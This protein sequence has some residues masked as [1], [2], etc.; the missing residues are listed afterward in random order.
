MRWISTPAYFPWMSP[1]YVKVKYWFLV[2]YYFFLNFYFKA[3]KILSAFF[4]QLYFLQFYL[5]LS[6]TKIVHYYWQPKNTFCIHPCILLFTSKS[7]NRKLKIGALCSRGERATYC[8]KTNSRNFQQTESGI[9]IRS[10][11]FYLL[12]WFN[13]Y[14][15]SIL[16]PNSSNRI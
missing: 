3:T 6:V 13:L 11:V 12:N 5:L 2:F 9:L 1:Y 14:I 15:I 16:H 10:T 7:S 4:M 8:K